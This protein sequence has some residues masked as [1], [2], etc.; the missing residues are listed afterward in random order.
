MPFF[1]CLFGQV[2]PSNGGGGLDDGWI[3][4]LLACTVHNVETV[5]TPASI[6]QPVMARAFLSAE[7]RHAESHQPTSPPSSAQIQLL[8][9]AAA[10]MVA[11]STTTTRS[12]S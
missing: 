8:F 1:C 3:L 10:M 12:W 5:E 4:L 6:D 9:N 2:V 7:N 11:A